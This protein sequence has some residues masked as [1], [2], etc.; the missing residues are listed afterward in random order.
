MD[1]LRYLKPENGPV[2][3][4]L[5]PPGSTTR[6]SGRTTRVLVFAVRLTALTSFQTSSLQR[7]GR[8]AVRTSR[9][10]CPGPLHPAPGYYGAAPLAALMASVWFLL[11]PPIDWAIYLLAAVNAGFALFAVDLVARREVAG[12]NR[13]LV[14]LLLLLTPFYCVYGQYFNSDRTLLWAWPLLATHWAFLRAISRRRP[15]RRSKRA[16][17]P[18]SPALPRDLRSS[19]DI[20]PFSCSPDSSQRRWCIPRGGP[21]CVR[22]RHGFRQRQAP[23]SLSSPRISTGSISTTLRPLAAVV[24]SQHVAG[25]RSARLLQAGSA[26]YAGARIGGHRSPRSLSTGWRCGRIGRRCAEV[27]WPSDAQGRMLP[28]LRCSSCRWRFG[29]CSR[30]SPAR[31]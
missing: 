29:R 20:S 31:C 23:S 28:L 27:I 26:S 5:R 6:R 22:P 30:C 10:L 8:G 7:L 15:A 13:I 18:H 14:L 3:A 17:G 19:A 4:V 1:V 11:A 9:H 16:Y 24:A 2:G 25:R 12:D 21:T